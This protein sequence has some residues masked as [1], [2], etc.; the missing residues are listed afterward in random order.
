MK[1]EKIASQFEEVKI[2]NVQ[3]TVNNF[4]KKAGVLAELAASFSAGRVK[5]PVSWQPEGDC[6]FL[7][8]KL[9]TSPRKSLA[10]K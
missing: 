7:F 1:D 4:L 10:S 9:Y 5:P 2:T 8:E 3:R 6:S